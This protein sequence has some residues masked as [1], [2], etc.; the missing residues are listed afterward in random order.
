MKA[1]FIVPLPLLLRLLLSL[2]RR[3]SVNRSP[4]EVRVA[5]PL[6]HRKMIFQ[7]I[8][9]SFMQI[10]LSWYT[11]PHVTMAGGESK[12]PSM[13]ILSNCQSTCLASTIISVCCKY[14]FNISISSRMVNTHINT[15]TRHY[16]ISAHPRFVFSTHSRYTSVS[17]TS[18]NIVNALVLIAQWTW[19]AQIN[20]DWNAKL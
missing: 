15:S 19:W 14:N 17:G 7:T 9:V 20:F 5:I 11:H 1:K 12:N 10:F 6:C 18:L 13:L 4:S 16:I 3:P 2:R 8:Y